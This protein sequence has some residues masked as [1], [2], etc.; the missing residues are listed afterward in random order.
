MLVMEF[1][2]LL[3][4]GFVCQKSCVGLVFYLSELSKYSCVFR[5]K[6]IVCVTVMFNNF[7]LISFAM[8]TKLAEAQVS[9]LELAVSIYVE[10]DS[11]AD[12]SLEQT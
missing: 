1:I 11:K 10:S 8:L 5:A 7:V 2:V 6:G 4:S 3:D 9:Y 12:Q